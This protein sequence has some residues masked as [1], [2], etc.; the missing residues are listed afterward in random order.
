MINKEDLM[1]G[2]YVDYEKTTHVITSLM[3]DKCTS[4]WYEGQDDS[5]IHSY[6]HIDPLIITEADLIRLGFEKTIAGYYKVVYDDSYHKIY[7][8][9]DDPSWILGDVREY[10]LAIEIRQTKKFKDHDF[11]NDVIILDEFVWVM[12]VHE[13]QNFYR[14]FVKKKLEYVK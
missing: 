7:M 4:M 13:L 3:E 2:N 8:L 5:Y 9:I 10:P 14:W 12:Y 11:D 6:D 1:I